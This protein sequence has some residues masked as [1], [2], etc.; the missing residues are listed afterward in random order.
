MG[1]SHI[2]DEFKYIFICLLAFMFKKK[3]NYNIIESNNYLIGYI[4]S[5]IINLTD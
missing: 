1:F 4:T 2:S 5:Y 3:D